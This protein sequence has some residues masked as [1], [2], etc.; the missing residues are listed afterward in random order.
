MLT[1]AN[2]TDTL[3]WTYDNLDRVATEASTKNA[4]TVGYTYDDAGNRTVLSLDGATHVTYGYD[5]QSRLTSI[6]RGANVFGFGYDTA[7]RRTSMTYPNGVVTTLRLRR[8][9]A[10]HL[11]R[12]E[13]GR[14]RRSRASATSSTRRATARARRRST[15]P[16]TTATTSCT[17]SSRRTAPRAR[18]R[19]GASRT[20]PSGT[21]RRTRR[22][23]RRN[24]RD[25]QQPEPAPEPRSPE[26]PWPSAGRRTSPP[27]VTCAGKP[28]QTAADNSFAARRRSAPATPTSP[29]RRRT[30]S[31]NARTNTYRVSTSGAGATLH[32]RSKWKPHTKDRRNGQLGLHLERREP[33][34]QGREE[35][36]RGGAV[37][38]RPDG[39]EGREGRGR[40]DNS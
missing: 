7:S 33:A 23:T 8:R 30:P 11:A 22:T 5:P 38:L 40:R 6:T 34:H 17:A 12:R 32:V 18:R 1:A 9:V 27:T 14:R 13:P 36:R 26:A 10:S 21:A 4:S 3:T 39:Q 20:T 15:G 16:R 35:R 25:L 29:C 2:G 28:A 31:G 24:G 19:A 37:R